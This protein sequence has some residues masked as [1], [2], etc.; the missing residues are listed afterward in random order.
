MDATPDFAEFMRRVRGGDEA[1]AR[2][3]IEQYE[4]ELRIIARVRMRDPLLR[5]VL[6]STDVCQS[7]LANFFVRAAL[8][9]FELQTPQDLLN[10]LSVMVRNRTID[11]VRAQQADRRGVERRSQR[12]SFEEPVDRRESPSTIASNNEL[13]T[14]F[15]G[16]LSAEEL[17]LADL[18]RD[19]HTWD[20]IS[21]QLGESPEALRKRFSRAIDRV[22][23]ELG[24]ASLFRSH[25]S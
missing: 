6:D 1:A 24:L 22:S 10:L 11:H 14:K 2:E 9:E 13:I 7:V 4:N 21:R 3:L 17:Q 23:A 25:Q 16:R 19:G 15:C 20:S 5:G 8:G 12:R 18:R